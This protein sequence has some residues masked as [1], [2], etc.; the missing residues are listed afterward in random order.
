MLTSR[1]ARSPATSR[2]V[3]SRPDPVGYSIVKSVPEELVVLEQSPYHQVVDREPDRSTPVGV[4][5]VHRCPGLGGFVVDGRVG[6]SGTRYGSVCRFDTDR[7]PCGD[8]NASSSNSWEDPRA[9]WSGGHDGQQQ[10]AAFTSAA[11]PPVHDLAATPLFHPAGE[12]LPEPP[13]PIDASAG[14]ARWPAM[15]GSRRRGSAP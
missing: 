1:S 14:H 11:D 3:T 4:S 15:R 9:S 5:A 8:R 10:P 7:R 13:E 12:P 6:R 2:S